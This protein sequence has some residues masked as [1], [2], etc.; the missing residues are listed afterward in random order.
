MH[1]VC[2]CRWRTVLLH[3]F[4]LWVMSTQWGETRVFTEWGDEVF[5]FILIGSH[6]TF[7]NNSPVTIVLTRL[8]R[9]GI[10]HFTTLCLSLSLSPSVYRFQGMNFVVSE[11]QYEETNIT[12]STC[13]WLGVSLAFPPTLNCYAFV[14]QTH[15]GSGLKGVVWHFGKYAY[16]HYWCKLYVK[17]NTTLISVHKATATTAYLST[18]SGSG[19]TSHTVRAKQNLPTSN[20]KPQ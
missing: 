20:F 2:E 1:W 19:N 9:I 3:W 14:G 18:R 5:Y 15:P 4:N 11:S 10:L 12:V 6:V 13:Y 17:I 7:Q 8:L 16:S